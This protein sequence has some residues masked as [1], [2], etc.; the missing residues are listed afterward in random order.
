MKLEN[1]VTSIGTYNNVLTSLTSNKTIVNMIDG[2]RLIKSADKVNW[3]TGNLTYTLKITN[4]TDKTYTGS[5]ITDIID[6]KLVDF[7][8]GSLIINGIKANN[9]QYKYDNLSNTLTINLDDIMPYQVQILRFSVRKKVNKHFLL[10]SNSTITL[11][12]GIKI[13]SNTVGVISHEIKNTFSNNWCG[14]PYWR[15]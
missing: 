6:S 14:T 11:K 5:T 8:T 10:T 13:Q 7:I 3:G 4:Q 1:T 9:N 15:N 12:S 2:I